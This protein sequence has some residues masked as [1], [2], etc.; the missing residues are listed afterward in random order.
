VVLPDHPG[1][2]PL[3]GG[4]PR[5]G[6]GLSRIKKDGSLGIAVINPFWYTDLTENTEKEVS[7]QYFGAKP[8]AKSP[9]RKAAKIFE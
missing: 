4:D 7:S 3:E 8:N 2:E 6:E 5:G 1:G 9:R